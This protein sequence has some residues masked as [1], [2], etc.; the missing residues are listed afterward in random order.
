MSA[1]QV[2]IASMCLTVC[3]LIVLGDVSA[4]APSESRNTG[5]AAD[6]SKEVRRILSTMKSSEYSH[7]TQVDEDRGE[8]F[9]DCSGLAC[10]VLQREFSQHYQAI[11]IPKGQARAVA[12]DFYGFFNG[13]PAAPPG[14]NGWQ[15]IS[16]LLD[17]QPG[18]IIAWKSDEPK[19]GSTGHVVFVDS[20][21]VH[22]KDGQVRIEVIDSTGQGHGNDTRKAGQT[23]VGR[24]TMWFTIGDKGQPTGYRWRAA[25]GKLHERAIAIGR[26][27]STTRQTTSTP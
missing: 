17:A 16:R 13:L 18:D 20:T 11:P 6:L 8:Y 1:R 25:K 14:R 27:I 21:P 5:E 22:L 3:G 2:L 7:K 10:Y 12:A 23:G 19:P 4:A 26:I 9:L 24:G 15:K